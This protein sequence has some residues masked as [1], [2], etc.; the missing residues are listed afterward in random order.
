MTNGSTIEFNIVLALVAP[1]WSSVRL[2][3]YKCHAR[4]VVVCLLAKNYSPF[5][6]ACLIVVN[7]R[8]TEKSFQR[9][10]SSAAR[11]RR[12]IVIIVDYSMR[13]MYC[14]RGFPW[15]RLPFAYPYTTVLDITKILQLILQSFTLGNNC[16]VASLCRTVGLSKSSDRFSSR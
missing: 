5:H 1:V 13:P 6:M 11:K 14:F 7:L 3:L 16:K 9:P 10:R 8:L 12:G 2:G 4:L 15:L